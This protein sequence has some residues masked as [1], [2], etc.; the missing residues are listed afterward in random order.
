[1]LRR[2]FVVGALCLIFSSQAMAGVWYVAPGGDD[3]DG[4][5]WSTA[6][7]HIQDGIDAAADAGGGEVWVAGGVYDEERDAKF[8]GR[9][10]GAVVLRHGV[11]VYGGFSG[12]E[13]ARDQRDW[14]RN[15]TVID[16]SQSRN[17]EAGVHAVVGADFSTLDGFVITGGDATQKRLGEPVGGGLY[18]YYVSPAVRNCRFMGNA[19]GAIANFYS[20]PTIADC[21]FEDNDAPAVYNRGS[22]SVLQN[23]VFI[24][25]RSAKDTGSAIHNLY[26]EPLIVGATFEDNEGTA[27][28]NLSAA[29]QMSGIEFAGANRYT[30]R[31]PAIFNAGS[32]PRFNG[33]EQ[34]RALE[35]VMVSDATSSP[36]YEPFS[37]GAALRDAALIKLQTAGQLYA[38]DIYSVQPTQGSIQGGTTVRATGANF[39]Q[40]TDVYLGDNPVPSPLSSDVFLDFVAP[41][42]A[43]NVKVS[44]TVYSGQDVL[45]TKP[46]A[47]QYFSPFVN[48]SPSSGSVVGGLPVQI[49]STNLSAVDSVYFK[50]QPATAVQA[51]SDTVVNCI[52]PAIG[53]A[54]NATVSLYDGSMLIAQGDNIF[55]YLEDSDQ[56]GFTD[57]E[58]GTVDTD[59]DGTPDFLDT[60]SDN[61]GLP[62]A[63]EPAN[64]G[65][66]TDPDT[67]NDGLTDGEEVDNQTEVDN[68]DSDGDG[69]DDGTEVNTGS[70]PNG[71]GDVPTL[72]S[73]LQLFDLQGPQLY[74]T[75]NLNYEAADVDNDELPD[76]NQ[77]TLVGSVLITPSSPL[78]GPVKSAYQDNLAALRTE[79]NFDTQLEPFAEVLAALLLATDGLADFWSNALGLTNDYD[80]FKLS[81]AANEPFSGDGDFDGDGVS[82]K[83]EFLNVAANQ[84][85]VIDF[86]EAAT[87]ANQSGEPLPLAAWPAVIGLGIAGWTLL[88]R[89]RRK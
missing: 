62:D 4:R 2:E 81:K 28:Y 26:S 57:A 15:R 56:D 60:D 89:R 37:A 52:T 41:A 29:P 39:S 12:D 7:A 63:D 14:N 84:G 11:H 10:L 88:R 31:S 87:N 53:L 24:A 61:D 70:D 79:P 25:N 54:M 64:N 6:F 35:E 68:S 17:G 80:S 33:L 22:D 32:Q 69:V 8:A 45:C 66:R 16:A 38:C 49:T 20:T 18:N 30:R 85:G 47:F 74:G 83:Q 36:S 23:N 9:R 44:I 19:G 82:N 50:D 65:D 75:E 46:D 3:G 5:S 58:E 42:V 43:E 48:I 77:A 71:G 21:T 34:Q 27:I 78:F 67:D 1:M 72:T 40:A 86:V 73:L 76:R 55:T 51:A 13:T 59:N